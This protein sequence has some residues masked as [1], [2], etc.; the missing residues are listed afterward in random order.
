MDVKRFLKYGGFV[1]GVVLIA[2]GAAAIFLGVDGRSTVR[3]SIAQE[4]VFFE[5]AAEDPATAQYASKWSEQQVRT[6]DQ[7]RA[8][9]QIMRQHALQS[10]DGLTYA[11]MG[12][13]VAA[14]NPDDPAGT[15]DPAAALVDDEGKPVQNGARNTWVTATA[16]STALN[17]SYLAE[18]TSI[19][20][21][22]VGVAL[23]L[24]GVGFVVLA[25]F[26]LGASRRPSEAAA[27]AMVAAPVSGD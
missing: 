19:F 18:Q 4:Q 20:G 26:A 3:D 9:A 5:N 27:P 24:A 16:I 7:A 12:R 23:L 2:F 8:F 14:A 15:S 11:Q 25:W 1:A 22:V 21:M 17:M 10:S 13:F 6:G